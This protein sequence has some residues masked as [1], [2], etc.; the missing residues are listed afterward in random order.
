MA[1]YVIVC[2]LVICIIMY[3]FIIIFFQGVH[4]NTGVVYLCVEV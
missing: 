3:L 1:A 4:D 2:L